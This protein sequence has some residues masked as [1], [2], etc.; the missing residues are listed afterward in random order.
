MVTCLRDRES[1]YRRPRSVEEHFW[2]NMGKIEPMS[3]ELKGHREKLK[4]LKSE[5][6]MSVHR[7]NICSHA[8]HSRWCP[9]LLD[10]RRL[11]DEYNELAN[12]VPG[13]MD[14][15]WHDLVCEIDRARKEIERQ[16]E[17]DE[18][19]PG[20]EIDPEREAEREAKKRPY[21]LHMA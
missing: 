1:G 8:D 10:V 13:L 16:R 12:K 15:A 14:P 9:Y 4:S 3:A 6:G 11:T 21:G 18:L 19:N 20:R 5:C 7:Y 17:E 2:K